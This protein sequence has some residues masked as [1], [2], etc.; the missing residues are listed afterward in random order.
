MSGKCCPCRKVGATV[1]SLTLVLLLL[2]SLGVITGGFGEFVM[3][4]WPVGLLV[5][6]VGGLC[7]CHGGSCEK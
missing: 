5:H 4:W 3:T 6:T 7:K 1:S 2:T